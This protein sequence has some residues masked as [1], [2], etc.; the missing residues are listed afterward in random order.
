[1]EALLE[2]ILA[3]LVEV[4]TAESVMSASDLVRMRLRHATVGVV[5]PRPLHD[6]DFLPTEEIWTEERQARLDRDQDKIYEDL[7][8]VFRGWGCARSGGNCSL[9][10]VIGPIESSV[11][12][13]CKA[14]DLIVI[15]QAR[16]GASRE[17]QTAVQ[18]VIFLEIPAPVII[19]PTACP[20]TLGHYVVIAWEDS[21]SVRKTVAG[22]LPVLLAC[23]RIT[24]L[25]GEEGKKTSWHPRVSSAPWNRLIFQ[26]R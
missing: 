11:K 17:A 14:A 6:A 26:Y 10:Q 7:N 20:A 24:L 15:G 12:E 19:V 9:R 3:I 16:A 1:V 25:I 18:T 13:E 4:D 5:H 2:R 23:D 8:D 22:M 21:A